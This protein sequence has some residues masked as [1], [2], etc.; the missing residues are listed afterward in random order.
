MYQNFDKV[1]DAID[2]LKVKF[3]ENGPRFTGRMEIFQDVQIGILTR[4]ADS[5]TISSRTEQDHSAKRLQDKLFETERT[6]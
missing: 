2:Q 4:A 3:H 6:I 5:F 1:K